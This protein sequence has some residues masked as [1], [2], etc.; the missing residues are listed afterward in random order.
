MGH[1]RGPGGAQN[2]KSQSWKTVLGWPGWLR[3]TRQLKAGLRQAAPTLNRG[4]EMGRF[5]LGSNRPLV[6][7]RTGHA[8]GDPACGAGAAVKHGAGNGKMID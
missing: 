8:P 1:G 2:D 4:S 5:K 3:R 6:L 7:F